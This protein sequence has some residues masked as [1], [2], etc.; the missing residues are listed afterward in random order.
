MGLTSDMLD[1][2]IGLLCATDEPLVCSS[3][4]KTSFRQNLDLKRKLHSFVKINWPVSFL[5]G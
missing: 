1:A 5:L 2:R 3:M 4:E